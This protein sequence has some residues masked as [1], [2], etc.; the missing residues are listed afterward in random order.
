MTAPIPPSFEDVLASVASGE[1][2][3]R[4]GNAIREHIEPLVE[5][6]GRLLQILHSEDTVRPAARAGR[7]R[8]SF[9]ARGK[10]RAHRLRAGRRRAARARGTLAVTHARRR[11]RWRGCDRGAASGAGPARPAR[12]GA[13]C[14]RD[15][16][17]P[18]PEGARC[19]GR[20]LPPASAQA[21][22]ALAA[23]VADRIDPASMH[24]D[25]GGVDP[26]SVPR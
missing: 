11:G 7:Q 13:R 24:E 2:T 1:R 20:S 6:L 17:V 14:R 25:A 4:E 26:S 5:L 8:R 19:D 16:R 10:R 3:G 15:P 22:Q 21:I 12:A 9:V 23:I 18:P